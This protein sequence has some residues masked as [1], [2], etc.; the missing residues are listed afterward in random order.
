MGR[1][2]RVLDLSDRLENATSVFEPSPHKIDYLTP[3]VSAQV[4]DEKRGI[5][6]SVWPAGV[7]WASEIVTIPTHS[8]THVDAPSH[9]G[10]RADGGKA[11][12]IDQVPMQWCMGDGV[13][14][15]FSAKPAGYG[16]TAEDVKQELSRIGYTIKPF[17]IVLIRTDVSKHF[18]RP[19]YAQLHPGLARSATEFLVDAGVRLIGID[20]WGLD[21][22]FDAMLKD[23]LADPNK[24]FWETHLLGREK[25]YSQIEKLCNLDQLP[26][27]FGFSIIALPI[28]LA[29]ASA[30]WSRVVAI[31]EDNSE[32]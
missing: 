4:I 1:N 16:I 5:P 28:N 3:D 18:K 24:Q 7:A 2:V 22:P 17:D 19:G 9:Y 15:D 10:P 25:E 26:Q 8:G 6:K 20:A 14:L 12:S 27:P 11:R 31:L 30:G 32:N 21:R 29:D 23:S 13:L